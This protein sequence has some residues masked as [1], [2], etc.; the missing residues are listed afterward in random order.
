MSTITVAD[1]TPAR[2]NGKRGDY[3]AIFDAGERY[4]NGKKKVRQFYGHDAEEAEGKRWQWLATQGQDDLLPPPEPPEDPFE[5][6]PYQTTHRGGNGT[7]RSEEQFETV[8]DGSGNDPERYGTDGPSLWF[9]VAGMLDNGI[10][11]PPR[12]TICRRTDGVGLF[13]AGQSCTVFGDPESGKTWLVLSAAVEILDGGGSVA[14]LDLDHN[15]PEQTVSRLVQ[16]GADQDALRDPQRFRY[17]EPEDKPHLLAIVKSYRAWRPNFVVVDSTG[18]LLPTLGLNS[19]NPDD[20]TQA[21]TAVMKPLAASGACVVTIDH[22]AKNSDSRAMGATGTYAKKRA[23]GGTSLRVVV[24]DQFTPGSG[25]SAYLYVNKDRPGG[26]RRYCP[27]GKKEPLA[28]L[29]RMTEEDD[30]LHWRVLIPE[31]APAPPST[32]GPGSKG[33]MT[34]DEA[35][36]KLRALPESERPKTNEEARKLLGCRNLVASAAMRIIRSEAHSGTVPDSHPYVGNGTE[37]SCTV[38]GEPLIGSDPAVTTHPNCDSE[39]APQ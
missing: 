17:V 9:D 21:N 31:D 28:G 33:G 23:V 4:P 13:Y 6:V 16:L 26:L 36:A 27:Q 1:L 12:P 34:E 10:P 22:M 19:A 38:C 30:G 35:L 37:R 7:E 11:E 32:E 18:E 5:T 24:D 8:P 20:Y 29:F 39:E 3:V 2:L 25:G 14:V 15:G